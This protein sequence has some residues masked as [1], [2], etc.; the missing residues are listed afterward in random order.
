MVETKA[1]PA[2]TKA[3]SRPGPIA[4]ASARRAAP[5]AVG[6]QDWKTIAP[7][8]LPMARVSLPWRTQMT[9]L[10]FSG[11]SVAMG[12]MTRARSVALMPSAGRDVAHRVD[13]DD[14]ADDDQPERDDDLQADDAQARRCRAPARWAPRSSRWKRSGARSP[15]WPV[16]GL[17]HEVRPDVDAR[18]G[19]R[20]ATAAAGARA[21]SA[22]RAGTPTAMAMP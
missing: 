15:P 9:L 6:M 20:G 14:G 12:A 19:R 21:R 4:Q 2:D 11:S 17:G 7:V 3:S 18:R 16:C 13:E 10:N 22:R 8:M 5:T 1:M